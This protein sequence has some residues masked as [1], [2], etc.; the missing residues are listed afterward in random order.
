MLLWRVIV[1]VFEYQYIRQ[2]CTL[3]MIF[4]STE[5]FYKITDFWY[6]YKKIQTYGAQYFH[7][8]GRSF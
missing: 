6:F 5:F 4:T 1:G 7:F 8:I 3:A 2:F